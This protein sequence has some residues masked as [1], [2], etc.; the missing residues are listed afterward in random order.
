V[1][2]LLGFCVWVP[3][4]E[5]GAVASWQTRGA[6]PRSVLDAFGQFILQLVETEKKRG[7]VPLGFSSTLFVSSFVLVAAVS[8]SVRRTR[9]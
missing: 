5:T 8:S 2:D 3:I 6:W 9:R 1:V 7:L 4:A